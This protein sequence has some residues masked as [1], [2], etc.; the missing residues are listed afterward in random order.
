MP[1]SQLCT[2]ARKGKFRQKHG[3]SRVK[4]ADCVRCADWV[5]SLSAAQDD[6]SVADRSRRKVVEIYR[7][8][9]PME[10]QESHS[11][12]VR[13]RPGGRVCAGVGE[14]LGLEIAKPG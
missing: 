1:S 6:W 5:S 10:E 7:P 4:G 3:R 12:G 2:N 14:D 8:G 9:K 11:G 13:R